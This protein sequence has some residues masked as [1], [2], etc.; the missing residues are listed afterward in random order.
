MKKNLILFIICISLFA[1][2]PVN[3][4]AKSIQDYKNEIAKLKKEKAEMPNMG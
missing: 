1:I 3:V 2:F 4:S